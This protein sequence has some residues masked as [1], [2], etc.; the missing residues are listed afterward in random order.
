MKQFIVLLPSGRGVKFRRLK[1]SEVDDVSL[2]AAKTVDKDASGL[3]FRYATLREGVRAMLTATTKKSSFKK[4][5]ELL[6]EGV[7]WEPLD[8]AKL[9]DGYDDYFGNPKDD[10]ILAE[11]YKTEHEVTKQE[12]EAILGKVLPVS[13]D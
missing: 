8:L 4:P 3:E 9:L 7:E 5:E 1:P 10:A 6:A 2:K 13:E 12:V 11:I